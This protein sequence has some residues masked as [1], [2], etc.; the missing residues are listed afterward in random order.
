M[1]NILLTSAA[2]LALATGA[3]LAQSGGSSTTQSPPAGNAASQMPQ[4]SNSAPAGAG[5]ATP[6]LGSSAAGSTVGATEG[7][8]MRPHRMMHGDRAGRMGRANPSI[9]AHTDPGMVD[10]GAAPP[11]TAYRG[12]AGS[13]LSTRATN[14]TPSARPEALGSRLPDP[15]AAGSTPRDLLEAAQRLLGQGRTGAAQEALERAETRVLSRTTD[16]SMASQ[17]DQAAMVQNIAQARRAL[18]ARDVNGAKQAIAMAMDDRI[19]P[20]G[21]ATNVGPTGGA[22]GGTTGSY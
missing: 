6:G 17:P 3:A 1:R 12:G 10:E 18:G 9:P 19:P 22:A 5:V 16:P 15:N 8:S 21:P 14:L 2:A 4:P 11:T 7:A 13:P 20:R